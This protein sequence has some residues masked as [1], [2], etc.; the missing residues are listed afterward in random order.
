MMRPI[1]GRVSH[2][3]TRIHQA[4]RIRRRS[5][6]PSTNSSA[7]YTR[8]GTIGIVTSENASSSSAK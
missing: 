1:W 2:Q 5:A 7:A 4:I 8:L 3:M 6:T